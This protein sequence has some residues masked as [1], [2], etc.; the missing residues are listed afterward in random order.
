M[1]P[2]PDGARDDAGWRRGRKLINQPHITSEPIAPPRYGLDR[3]SAVARRAEHLP[4]G[5]NVLSQVAFFD[6]GVRP[7]RPHQL[8]FVDD[9]TV[10]LDEHFQNGQRLG[11]EGDR[12]AIA[13]QDLLVHVQSEVDVE[14]GAV[15]RVALPTLGVR[16]LVWFNEESLILNAALP[17][18]PLQL[19]QRSCGVWKLVVDTGGVAK[20]GAPEC[21]PHDR[22]A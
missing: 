2:T 14:T 4:Q 1:A 3:D 10:A 13:Q 9:V 12:R 15:H 19:G 20:T 17:D 8:T 16:G 6:G 5:V 21:G 22:I 11:G 18:K 7:H